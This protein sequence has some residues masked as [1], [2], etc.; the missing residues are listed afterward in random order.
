[1]S[2]LKVAALGATGLSAS[3]V[4]A[5]MIVGARIAV[6]ALVVALIGHFVQPYLVTIG[7][8]QAGEPFRKIGFIIALGT[9]LGAALIDI[10]LILHEAFQRFRAKA[11]VPVEPV[12]DW[13]RVPGDEGGEVTFSAEALREL[14]SIGF[15]GPVVR[16]YF[17]SL[18]QAKQKN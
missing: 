1:M 8:L 16:T 17:A 15:G 13:K 3:T 12:E 2:T 4:G 7:W 10:V 5:G 18:P 9:I 14:Y 6:P 11:S